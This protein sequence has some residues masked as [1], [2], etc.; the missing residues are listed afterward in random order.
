MRIFNDRLRSVGLYDETYLSGPC[1]E[2]ET[3]R[4]RFQTFLE[5]V[6][7]PENGPIAAPLDVDFFWHTMQLAGPKYRRVQ[8]CANFDPIIN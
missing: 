2:L 5:L 7:I 8:C 6:L 3:A 1:I 4:Q